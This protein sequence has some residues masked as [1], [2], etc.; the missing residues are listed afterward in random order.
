[1][2]WGIWL[3]AE[4]DSGAIAAPP[5]I[6]PVQRRAAQLSRG[7]G[8]A[9]HLW[10]A[11]MPHILTVEIGFG[12][13]C[14]GRSGERGLWRG[15]RQSGTW[16]GRG[17]EHEDPL[18]ALYACS[19]GCVERLQAVQRA[20]DIRPGRGR[21]QLS[22]RQ[23]PQT[24]QASGMRRDGGGDRCAGGEGAKKR[25]VTRLR[26]LCGEAQIRHRSTQ[27]AVPPVSPLPGGLPDKANFGDLTKG[28]RS[29]AWGSQPWPVYVVNRCGLGGP[30]ALG[31]EL[32]P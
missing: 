15:G 4:R 30:P 20:R 24:S 13:V 11:K 28:S 18:L 21:G 29:Q 26:K 31:T 8:A 32:H 9:T 12:G 2:A 17:E 1:M 7:S 5:S 19:R 14:Q 10:Q 16:P 3:P 23:K 25:R 6:P 22:T 27:P